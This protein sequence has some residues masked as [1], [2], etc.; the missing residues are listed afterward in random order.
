VPIAPWLASHPYGVQSL[1]AVVPPLPRRLAYVDPWCRS[2]VAIQ[3]DGKVIK[4][5]V[6]K[7]RVVGDRCRSG[8]LYGFCLSLQVPW[9]MQ[10]LTLLRFP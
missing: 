6:I 5:R 9:P 3:Q 1:R 8:D 2:F 7:V 4:V 10:R